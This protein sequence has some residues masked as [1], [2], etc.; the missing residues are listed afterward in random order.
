MHGEPKASCTRVWH[1]IAWISA[2]NKSLASFKFQ[3]QGNLK[4]C[5]SENPTIPK[6]FSFSFSQFKLEFQQNQ[7]IFK[8]YSL[9]LHSYHISRSNWKQKLEGIVLIKAALQRYMIQLF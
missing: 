7:L 2:I 5:R 1:I 9:A 8:T 3:P 6:E 4:L